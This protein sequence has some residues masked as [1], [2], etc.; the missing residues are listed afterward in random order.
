[1]CY[2]FLPYSILGDPV[3]DSGARESR[4]GQKKSDRRKV[5]SKTR[6]TWGKCFSRV[7]PNG[8]ARSSSWIG[9]E[10]FCIFLPNQ[11][12]A[13]LVPVSCVLTQS[14]SRGSFVRHIP[15]LVDRKSKALFTVNV[16]QGLGTR[17]RICH[18]QVKSQFTGKFAAIER[19]V[20]LFVITVFLLIRD[21]KDRSILS[22]C[23]WLVKGRIELCS[24][25]YNKMKELFQCFYYRSVH[26]PTVSVF[27]FVSPNFFWPYKKIQWLHITF[28]L[29][30]L[31]IMRGICSAKV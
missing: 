27:I 15:S 7:V 12:A 5:K 22:S 25:F 8:L 28:K 2:Y 1:M 29:T 17:R 20:L 26:L 24:S 23:S 19:I 16:P 9:T 13:N 4:N 3:A 6:S 14:C 30:C 18:V 31:I 21:L 11:R 10:N